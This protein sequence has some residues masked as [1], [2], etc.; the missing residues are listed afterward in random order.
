MMARRK[1]I[2]VWKA[3]DIGAESAL[4]DK[5][6]AHSEV[7]NLSIPSRKSQCEMIPGATPAEAAVNLASKIVSLM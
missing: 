7:T 2:P 5:A 1:V 6:N 3:Q 4:L